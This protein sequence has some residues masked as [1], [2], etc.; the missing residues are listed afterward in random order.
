MRNRLPFFASL[1]IAYSN[2]WGNE[3][4]LLDPEAG[5]S[6]YI[7]F[8]GLSAEVFFTNEST[9]ADSYLWDFDDGTTST[10]ESPFHAFSEPGVY[11]VC[12][13]A[14][15]GIESDT[16]C[17]LIVNYLPPTSFFMFEGDPIVTFTDLSSNAPTSWFWD[18][19]DD[20]TSELQNP[21]HEFAANESYEVCLFVSNPVGDSYACQTVT[22]TSYETT[23]AAFTYSGDSEV[24]FT[25][26]STLDP[27]AW[28]WDFGDGTTDTIQNPTHTYTSNGTYNVCLTAT[29]AGGFDTYCE[30]VTISTI[31]AA[32]VADFTYAASGLTVEF[33][34]ISINSP[35]AWL[36]NFG[37]GNTSAEHNPTHTYFATGAYNVCL[38]ATNS[39]GE[40]TECKDI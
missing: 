10:E 25:D 6:Y 34:D 18:F 23:E 15:S 32:P 38:T 7:E 19:G 31:E 5:F 1:I 14:F 4:F 27:T 11:N 8:V 40:S 26:L 37:D 2:A 33:T 36:W 17:D 35:D 28:L 29:N 24:V 21:T 16:F 30:E 22:I 39:G 3:T 9:G 20:S 12:L 13:V